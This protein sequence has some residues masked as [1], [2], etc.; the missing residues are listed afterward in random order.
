MRK[1]HL[2]L[3]F[4]LLG[5]LGTLS[6]QPVEDWIKAAENAYEKKDYYSA[7]R[8]YD[9]A[10]KYD[11]ARMDLW[12]QLGESARAFTAYRS[13]EQAYQRVASS[14]VAD[15]FPLL[16]FRQAEVAQQRGH[17]ERAVALY[18][19]FITEQPDI[20]VDI[21]EEAER[22]LINAEWAR[23]VMSRRPEDIAVSHLENGINS[24]YSDFGFYRQHDT[25][26]YSSLRFTFRK[27]SLAPRR[28]ITKIL[29]QDT[30]GN[31]L[32]P[33]PE[34]INIPGRLAAHTAFSPD[35]RSV[36]FTLCDYVGAS[37][38]L[39]CDIY[40]SAVDAQGQWGRPERLPINDAVSTNTHPNVGIDPASGAACLYFVSDRAGGQGGLDLYRSLM[41][42][43]GKWGAVENL[44]AFNTAGNDVTPFYYAP[45]QVFYF[46]S[47][48][49]LTMGGYDIYRSSWNG[50]D[51]E[52][53]N[54]MG[55]PVNTSYNDL[56]Y[57]R[58]AEAETAYLASNRPDT[59]AIFWDE[60]KD[61][62]CNDIYSVGITD[63]FKLLVQTFDER[64]LSELVGTSV[65]LYEIGPNGRRLVDSLHQPTTHNFTFTVQ[66]GKQYELVGTKTGFSTAI[67]A[68]DMND[69]ELLSAREIVRK[70]Y[71][72]PAI[73][74]D[75]FTFVLPDSTDLVGCTVYLS[76]ITPEGD[77]LVVDSVVNPLAHDFHFNLERGKHYQVFGRQNGYT[78]ALAEVD[79]NDPK[80]A[81][82][83]RIRRDLYLEPGLVLEVYTFRLRDR[84]PLSGTT[85]NLYNYT[86]E[87]GEELIDS[88][89]NANGNQFW[90]KV[91]R[92]KRYVIRGA[93]VG[94]GPA[95]TSLDLT[96]PD[97]PAMGTY[98]RDLYLGQRLEVYTFDAITKEPLPG[99]EVKLIEPN[100]GR[101]IADRINPLAND[102]AFSIEYDIPYLFEVTRKGYESVSEPI[103]FRP[104]QA[105]E[106]GTIKLD[107]ELVPIENPSS[108]LPLLLYYDNDQPNPRSRSPI[109][110][111]EYVTTNVDYYTKKQEFI[112]TFTSGMEL[113]EAFRTR[114]RF[115]DFFDREVRG[116]RYDLEEFAKRLL[117]YLDAGGRFVM[118]LQ[119]FA[120]PRAPKRYNDILSARRIDAVKNF[121]ERY[122]DGAFRS[123]MAS[124]TLSFIEKAYGETRADPRA[125]DESAGERSSIYDI[126]ASLERRVEIRDG[127]SAKQ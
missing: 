71:L 67:D 103:I 121:F 68:L 96:G 102:F 89:R 124:G 59:A 3:F 19:R 55:V 93:R 118:D 18:D 51:W 72:S 32:E 37:A 36:Y 123:H 50:F 81:S 57:A 100:T 95:E 109:T 15:S 35:G 111:L 117:V 107:I 83:S 92:G 44:R 80:L 114:R 33:L 60:T 48:G 14:T 63:E 64:D 125:L 41:L 99:A 73:E 119:G 7:Y 40:T 53:P 127:D 76:E 88:T 97:V 82:V 74:L 30:A 8:Y 31:L 17:Y 25:L 28:E 79:T 94:Y 66:P 26:Y 101:V 90:W 4:L 24:A 16:L 2:S 113:E 87:R 21:A 20:S 91:E 104:D 42:E 75:V 23:E 52:R 69:P 22:N 61:A 29:R 105:D 62:C 86:D 115:N 34:Y 9:V 122:K 78:P 10:L 110:T 46:S 43:D 112:M 120:S 27:D 98:R 5:L 38:D 85:V 116:G 126:L 84:L 47:D 54:H 11:T 39:R 58:F 65:A 1:I 106:T 108:L 49:R 70:L 77:L 56:Y 45:T 13:A 6:A 12:Y